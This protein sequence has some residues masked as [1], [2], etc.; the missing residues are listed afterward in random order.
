MVKLKTGGRQSG[1]P[2]KV[3]SDIRTVLHSIVSDELDHLSTRLHT[4]DDDQRT[5]TLIKLLPYIMPKMQAITFND[6]TTIK[7]FVMRTLKEGQ[8]L[9]DV[10]DDII[11]DDYEIATTGKQLTHVAPTYSNEFERA[12]DLY[13]RRGSKLQAY[14][15]WQVL[16]VDD[17]ATI[18]KHIPRYI[19][20]LTA[21]RYQMHFE[22]YLKQR[23]FESEPPAR[24]NI[25]TG[26]I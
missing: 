20:S 7:R 14:K 24:P 8:D 13:E 2:N 11:D 17:H 15:Q 16:T 9:E 22:R 5:Y 10:Y 21:S 1:T 25:M 3:T 26:S 18:V 19:N 4:M 23:H 6:E 12:W